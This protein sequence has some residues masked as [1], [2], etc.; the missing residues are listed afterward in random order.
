MQVYI[1][2]KPSV[3]RALV[4]FFNR[5]GGNFKKVD[6]YFIDE[7]AS[8]VVTWAYGHLMYLKAPKEYNPAWAAWKIDT[9]P[10]QPDHFNFK[11]GIRSEAKKQYQTIKSLLKDATTVIHAGDPDREGQVLIDEL[12]EG[13]KGDVQRILL[14][15]LDDTSI[16]RALDSLSSNKKYKGLYEAGNGRAYI[17]WLVGMN[18]TR[19]FTI[20]ARY[21]GYTNTMRT[22]RVKSPTLNLIVQRWNEVQN[23]KS[24]TFWAAIPVVEINGDHILA[25]LHPATCF[26]N[27][28]DA[29]MIR[30]KLLGQEA[31]VTSLK[32]KVVTEEIKDLYSLDTL[33]IEANKH[34]GLSAKETLDFLQD[35]Y[36][37]KYVTYPRSDCK[38]LPK[39][40]F[41]ESKDI[42]NALNEKKVIPFPIPDPGSDMPKPFNDEKISAH[43]AIIPTA[44]IPDP[45]GVNDKQYDLYRLIVK[46][47]ASMFFPA[48]S[49]KKITLEMTAC[50]L[51][52]VVTAKEDIEKGFKVLVR[53]TEKDTEKTISINTEN[54]EKGALLKINSVDIQKGQTTPPE[55]YTEGSLI[56]AMSGISSENKELAAKLKEVKGIGTPATRANI[57]AELLQEELIILKKKSVIPTDAGIQLI[58]ILPDEIKSADYTAEMEGKLDEVQAGKLQLDSVLSDTMGFI[59]KVLDQ[60][61]ALTVVNKEYPCPV[62][63]VGFLHYKYYKDKDTGEENKY[64]ACNNKSCKQK[65]FPVG[66]GNKPKIVQCPKCNK[67]YFK[68]IKSKTGD[69]FYACSNYPKCR[70]TMNA[71]DFAE[72]DKVSKKKEK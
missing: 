52:L 29:L 12:L 28:T 26:D 11:K 10:I 56:K 43:H 1:T 16:K 69:I 14:N 39:S 62:C 5:H 20:K 63:K 66:R 9:L 25:K 50:D 70:T 33:Q 22:G 8:A 64:Y 55:L 51:N 60:N 24:K 3:A 27:E 36:E 71:D 21:G 44:V 7:K 68:T 18:F 61:K 46:K 38:Y 17:D 67:G 2:E 49:Y 34:L 37:K 19:F 54:I 13:F 41:S 23:F 58:N 53:K 59:S 35:L 57:I 4:D 32:N 45:A 42:I 72:I 47:Y 15:A 65:Y 31:P 40:Q 48:Y 30:N 6:K